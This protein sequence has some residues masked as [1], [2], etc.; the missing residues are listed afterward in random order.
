[1]PYI[2]IDDGYPESAEFDNNYVWFDAADPKSVASL[3]RS[4]PAGNGV[5]LQE[6]RAW[7]TGRPAEKTSRRWKFWR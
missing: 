7:M 4:L 5:L 3:E 1:M 6:A 2:F